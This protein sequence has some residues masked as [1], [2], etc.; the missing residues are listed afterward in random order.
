MIPILYGSQTGTGVHLSRI[1][2]KRVP[3]SFALPIDSFDVSQINSFPFVI[4]ICSTHGDGQCPFN[5]SRFYHMVMSH[6]QKMFKFKFA[7]L[8]LGDSSYPKYNYCAKVLHSRIKHLGGEV[9]YKDYCNSQDLNGIYDGFSRF[10]MRIM[11]YVLKGTCTDEAHASGSRDRIGQFVVESR[12]YVATVV[13]NSLVTPKDYERK[14]FEVVFDIPEYKEFYPGDCLAIIPENTLDLKKFFDF[15]DDQI[16]KLRTTVDF[17]SI[18]QQTVF[19]DLAGFCGDERLRSKLREI[20]S[21]YDLYHSYV[22]VP[23]RNILEVICDFELK[24]PFDYLLTVNPIHPRYYSFSRINGRYHVLYNEINFK[25]YMSAPRLGLCSEYLSTL[26]GSIEVEIVHSKLF[27][28]DKKLLFFATGT[29]ITLPRSAIHFFGDKEIKVFYGFR[30]YG[31]DQLC[32]EELENVHYA[33]SRDDKRYI[34]DV[35]RESPVENIDEWL[36]FVSG[37]SRLNKEIRSLLLEV[38]GKDI[39]F[40]SETW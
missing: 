30:H 20:G 29:G 11:D 39:A 9:I 38:H 19:N 40:Q 26:R 23:K 33:A 7:I 3:D 15:N 28:D 22:V 25:T 8:G 17:Y 16:E 36:V 24:I 13:S 18:V 14:I 5:M 4:F 31:K 10:S 32:R 1:L 12:R 27:C 2:E 34:M 21:D 37:N 35:Y 6:D